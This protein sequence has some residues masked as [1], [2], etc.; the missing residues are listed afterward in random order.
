MKTTA[1]IVAAGKGHRAG[2]DLPKQYQKI[3]GRAVLWH[4]IKALISHPGINDVRVVIS[5]KDEELYRQSIDGFE[6]SAPILG[7]TER[8]DSVFAGLESLRAE[9]APDVV[10]IHDAAR[11][12]LPTGVTDRLLSALEQGAAGV[13]PALPVADTLKASSDAAVIKATVPRAGLFRAQTP[14]AFQFDALYSAYCEVRAQGLTL[15]DDASVLEAIGKQVQLVEGSE[16]LKK[17]TTAEDLREARLALEVRME[18]RTGS[19]FDVHRFGA[20]SFVT[21]GGIEIAHSQGLVGHSDADVG[22][23]ALTDAIFGALGSGD[24]GSHFPPSDMQWKGAASDIFLK[25]AVRQ[26]EDAG[27]RIVNLDLTLICERPKIGPHRERMVARIAEICGI[28]PARVSVKA[29]TTEK[30]GFTGRSEG[31]AA[32]A[33]VSIQLPAPEEEL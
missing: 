2:G 14:Q 15:T 33:A 21:L 7:G 3:A 11:P 6:L 26:V 12:F 29:T 32:Q 25:E 9:G 24:I 10:L 17:L 8:Q 5:E 13:I 28:S 18:T 30:L 1:L 27:G 19:G 20:G 4:A 22:L 31:I 16:R 23:H